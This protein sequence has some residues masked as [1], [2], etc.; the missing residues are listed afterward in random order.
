MYFFEIRF[1]KKILCSRGGHYRGFLDLGHTALVI[2]ELK[3]YYG[4]LIRSTDV[5]PWHPDL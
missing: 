3:L 2:I 4:I 1:S 5:L